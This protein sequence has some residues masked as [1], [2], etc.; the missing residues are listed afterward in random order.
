MCWW[1]FNPVPRFAAPLVEFPPPARE[2]DVLVARHPHQPQD[3]AGEGQHHNK[4][5]ECPVQRGEVQQPARVRQQRLKEVHGAHLHRQS[6]R[7]NLREARR[8]G[9][10][11]SAKRST[12]VRRN[13][14]ILGPALMAGILPVAAQ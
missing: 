5:G 7:G 10:A 1:L 11:T 12:S 3:V 9:G 14:Q 8:C 2:L 6:A 13:F 4:G